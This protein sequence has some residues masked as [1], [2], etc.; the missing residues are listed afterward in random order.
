MDGQYLDEL[1]AAERLAQIQLAAQRPLLF[2][3][4]HRTYLAMKFY[5]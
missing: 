2:Y 3:A 1:M 4:D 5:A